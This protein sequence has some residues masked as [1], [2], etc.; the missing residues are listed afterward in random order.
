MTNSNKPIDNLRASL[1]KGKGILEKFLIRLGSIPGRLQGNSHWLMLVCIIAGLAT[2]LVTHVLNLLLHFIS[3]NILGRLDPYGPNLQFLFLPTIGILLAI[4]FARYIVRMPLSHGTDRIR[5]FLKEQNYQLPPRLMWASVVGTSIT[6]GFGGSAG[7]EGPSA[8]TGS[9]I[10]SN[11]GRLFRLT[12]EE[13]RVMV[14]IGAGAGIAGI[15]RSPIGGVMFTLEVLQMPLSTIPVMA[16]IVACLAS[17][18]S[19]YMLAGQQFDVSFFN[20]IKPEGQHL[21]L[22]VLLGIVCGLYSIYYTYTFL[23]TSRSLG[24]VSNR[25]IRGVFAGIIIGLGVYFFP[26]L[27]ATGYSS[28]DKLLAGDNTAMIGYGHFGSLELSPLLLMEVALGIVLVKGIVCS[29][30]NNGGGIVG[31]FAPTLFAGGFVGFIFAMASNTW[32]GC[33]LHIPNYIFLGMAGAMSGIIEAPMMAIF[34]TAEMANRSDFF[35]P[36]AIVSLISWSV[37]RLITPHMEGV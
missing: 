34:L 7:A 21:W 25:W 33:S 13:M 10:A 12:E 36:L 1:S 6:L 20:S 5:K 17:G 11:I 9:A 4:I 26:S 35:W 16:L 32:F 14:G 19:S 15:F 28:L 29:A 37:R 2:G 31:N 8:Y 18:L 23:V 3:G 27:Y 22:V 30:T 24:A